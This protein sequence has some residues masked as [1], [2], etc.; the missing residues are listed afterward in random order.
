MSCSRI[1][2]RQGWQAKGPLRFA[3]DNPYSRFSHGLASTTQA[4]VAEINRAA[5]NAENGS[6]IRV[7]EGEYETTEPIIYAKG[8]ASIHGIDCAP[9]ALVGPAPLF[10]ALKNVTVTST[11]QEPFSWARASS[12]RYSGFKE[13][14]KK[15]RPEK[16]VLP[17]QDPMEVQRM[18]QQQPILPLPPREAASAQVQPTAMAIKQPSTVPVSSSGWIKKTRPAID[19]STYDEF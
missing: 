8:S 11:E 10:L 7:L 5:A 9:V 1:I 6:V 12:C 4:S 18:T 14:A 15:P 2:L 3:P 16:T 19:S 13:K 17:G